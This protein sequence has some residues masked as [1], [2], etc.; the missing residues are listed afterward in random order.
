MNNKLFA[1]FTQTELLEDLIE[2]ISTDY[3]INYG[4][5][6]ILYIKSTNEYVVTYNTDSGN[7]GSL[8]PN[9]IS[10]HRKKDTN[11]LYTINALNELIKRL[12]GGIVDP[13][14]K[15]NW[16][17]YKNCILLTQQNEFKSLNTKLYQ[18]IEL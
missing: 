11:T 8:P 7:I 10:V 16:N 12:N 15:V 13:S 17:H 5:L 9:T 3:I 4:K 14:F 18:I 2:R 1:S 6:F